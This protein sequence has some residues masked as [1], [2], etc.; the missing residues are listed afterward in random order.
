MTAGAALTVLKDDVFACKKLS[1]EFDYYPYDDET[2]DEGDEGEGSARDKESTD[3]LKCTSSHEE[4]TGA[5]FNTNTVKQATCLILLDMYD[6][7]D[8]MELRLTLCLGRPATPN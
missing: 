6:D 2:D 3:A 5:F 4:V 7:F 1:Y 8:H